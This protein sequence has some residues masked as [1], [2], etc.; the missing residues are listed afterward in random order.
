MKKLAPLFAAALL[1]LPAAIADEPAHEHRSDGDWSLS[2]GAGVLT[3]VVS[4]GIDEYR[5]QAL[6][7]ID[8]TYRDRYYL[9]VARGLGATLVRTGGFTFDA[10]FTYDDGREEKHARAELRGMGDVKESVEITATAAYAFCEQFQ[11]GAEFAQSLN[12]DG[13][14]GFRVEL[15]ARTEYSPL[16]RLTLGLQPY[17]RFGSEDTMQALYGVSAAQSLTSGYRRFAP[18]GGAELCGARLS[19]HVCLTDRWSLVAEADG[20]ALLGDTKD[21][22]LTRKNSQLFGGFAALVYRF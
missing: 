13:Y 2:V 3:H 16:P 22:P 8:L 6:P 1:Q 7:Y 14:E 15:S 17:L 9:S 10:A 21:S 18:A 19:A 12:D 11:F 5:T 20:G 4:P